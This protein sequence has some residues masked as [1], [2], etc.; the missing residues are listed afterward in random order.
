MVKNIVIILIAYII[1]NIYFHNKKI[2]GKWVY[3]IYSSIILTIYILLE[4]IIFS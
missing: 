3:T 2:E 4:L 1:G